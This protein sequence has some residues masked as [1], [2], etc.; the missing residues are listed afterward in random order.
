MQTFKP[1]FKPTALKNSKIWTFLCSVTGDQVQK[2]L[3]LKPKATDSWTR[4]TSLPT[5]A[6]HTECPVRSGHTCTYTWW[7]VGTS[8]CCC[9]SS[10]NSKHVADRLQ[11]TWRNSWGPQNL[12]TM[13]FAAKFNYSVTSRN[14]FKRQMSQVCKETKEKRKT[15]AVR[16]TAMHK[17]F[18]ES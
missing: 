7:R 11:T 1:F 10:F 5:K 12:I 6:G 4:P 14:V 15:M 17:L 13:T 18:R 9:W 3:T 16:K 2:C 8:L